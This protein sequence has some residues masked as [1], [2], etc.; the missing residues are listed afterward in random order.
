[1]PEYRHRLPQLDD[2]VFLTDGGLETTLIFLDGLDLPE[3]AAFVLVDDPAG[4]S[5][6]ERYFAGYGELAARNHTG[7]VLETPTWRAS[8]DWGD[9]LG[10][11]A[12]PLADANR[13]SVA[14]IAEVRST[15]A[16]DDA[17]IVISGC[18]GPRGDGY[19]PEATMSGEE[20]QQYHRAQIDTFA[21]SDADMIGAITMTHPEEAIGI[22]RAAEQAGMPSAISFTVETDGKLPT[23][24]SLADA[25]RAVDAATNVS[26]AYYMVNCAHPTHFGSALAPGEDWA[27][28]I[29]GVRANASRMNHAE[30]DE[31][32]ELDRGDPV[33]LASD[34]STLRERHPQLT[35]LGGCCG[36]DLEHIAEISAECSAPR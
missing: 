1:M 29:R 36:T 12:G 20:A 6:L 19:S 21:D 4:R 34:Y 9:R 10:Y 22:A 13:E 35:V 23:G 14:I 17:P 30:L 16:T 32:E 26:P 8:A 15:H 5:A 28:R 25:I 7:I 31:A 11:T 27:Q 24:E 3:F 33:E 18:V 2:A